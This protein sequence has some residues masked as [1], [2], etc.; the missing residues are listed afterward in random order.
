MAK[1]LLIDFDKNDQS[2]LISQKYDVDLVSTGSLFDPEKVRAAV[3]KSEALFL[4]LSPRSGEHLVGFHKVIDNRLAEG[5]L[6]VCFLEVGDPGSLTA[7]TGDLGSLPLDEVAR[8]ETITFSPK[9]LFHVPFERY[10]PFLKKAFRLSDEPL[11]EGEWNANQAGGKTLEIFA[12]SA[13]GFPVSALSRK[14]KG[15][16]LLLPSFGNKNAEIINFILR[17]MNF[18]DSL[19]GGDQMPHWLEKEEYAFPEVKVLFLKKEEEKKRHEEAMAEIDRLI[20]QE[21][22]QSQ[23]YFHNLLSAEGPELKKAVQETLRYLGWTKAIDVDEYWK[24]V[25]RDKEEDIWLLEESDKPVEPS[26]RMDQLIMVIVRAD[27]NWASDE[28]YALLQKYKGRRMQ[29]F[30]NTRMKAV[31]IG[32][33]FQATEPKERQNPFSAVQIEEAVKDGNGLMSTWELFKAVKAEKG[34]K[35]TK[36]SIREVITTRNGLIDFNPE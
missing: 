36:E 5:G 20:D 27:K 24:K 31:L 2:F 8:P 14:G 3:L 19:T 7:V 25:I 29:E 18:I 21:K 34:G 15:F 23:E 16:L 10:R 9:A 13:E 17:N 33:Y 28:D 32:N 12:K 1:V 26:L 22:R 30:G 11:P 35:L 4:S 6:A